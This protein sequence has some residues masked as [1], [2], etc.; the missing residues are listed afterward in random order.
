MIAIAASAIALLVRYVDVAFILASAI[1]VLALDHGRAVRSR[2]RRAVIFTVA[3]GLPTAVFALWALLDGGG[4]PTSKIYTLQGGVLAP[5]D[6]LADYVLPSGGP[7][8]LR[9]LAVFVMLGFV[10]YAAVWGPDLPGGKPD[11]DREARLLLQLTA[12]FLAVYVLFVMA[13]VAFFD[14]AVPIDARI[15]APIRGLWYAVVFAVAYRLLVHVWS[16]VVAVAIVGAAVAV[17][18]VTNWSNTR[19][20]LAQG[21]TLPYARTAVATAIDRIPAGVLIVSN[22]PDAVYS[23]NGRDAIDLPFVAGPPTPKYERE[24]DQVVQLLEARGG[25]L[26]LNWFPYNPYSLP[27]EL[28]ALDLHLVA[29]APNNRPSAALYEVAPSPRE[30]K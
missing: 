29:Q 27:P 25:Y 22:N 15:F 23:L 14:L 12:L 7:H 13:V 2:I 24:M 20:I 30:Q 10:L 6:R 26:A 5:I 16:S 8:A 28:Q 1:A 17:L 18:V 9:L 4:L 11:D 3:A 21:P 19:P